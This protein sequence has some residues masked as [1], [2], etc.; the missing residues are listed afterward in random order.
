MDGDA[1]KLKGVSRKQQR[2]AEVV[3]ERLEPRFEKLEEKL[4]DGSRMS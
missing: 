4:T 1:G 3:E 2:Q